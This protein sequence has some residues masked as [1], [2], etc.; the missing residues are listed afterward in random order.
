MNRHVRAM[1]SAEVMTFTANCKQKKSKRD[2]RK[3]VPLAVAVTTVA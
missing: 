3:R 1:L 2:L